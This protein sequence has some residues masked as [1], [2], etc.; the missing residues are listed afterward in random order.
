MRKWW[1]VS[2][3]LCVCFA[4]VARARA[5]IPVIDSANLA[6][7]IIQVA[8]AVT[9]IAHQ[10]RQIEIAF[11]QL[12]D[13]LKNSTPTAG[14]WAQAL[15]LLDRLG[16]N[17]EQA[18]ALAYTLRQLDAEFRRRYPGFVPPRDWAAEYE[19]WTSTV[20]DTLRGTLTSV[21]IQA[22]AFLA[23]DQRLDAITAKSESAIGRLQAIQA[24]NMIAAENTRHLMK[25]RQLVMMQIDAQNTFMATEA[26]KE[27]QIDAFTREWLLNA[28]KP[29]PAELRTQVQRA[30]N[31][32]R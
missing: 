7:N 25:L 14:I 6:Q 23:E 1:C 13:M 15:P 28:K 20:L 27:S 9:M 2:L 24:G 21:Q 12:Q 8:K 26:N 22:D 31:A 16:R 11:E 30:L 19:L 17:I 32:G 29:V 4:A 5:Q 18:Q 3:S 10:V